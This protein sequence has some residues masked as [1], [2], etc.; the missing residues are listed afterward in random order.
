MIT[1]CVKLEWR[2]DPDAETILRDIA[3]VSFVVQRISLDQIDWAASA[4]N[5]AR[6]SD[7]LNKEKI[8]DY[9]SGF[10]RG[11]VFPRIVVEY[12]KNGLYTILGGNQRCAALKGID[13][14][15]EI[16][17]YVVDPLTSG[18]REL[19]I[20]SLNSRHGWG[21]T[22][23][24]RI[25][26]AAYLVRHH[27]MHVDTVAKAMVVAASTINLRI[28]AENERAS[29][30]KKGI[31]ASSVSRTALSSIAGIADEALK[32]R[33]AKLA[34]SKLAT[35]EKV[36]ELATAVSKAKSKSHAT[37][38]IAEFAKNLDAVAE[39]KNKGGA[40]VLKKPRREKFLCMLNDLSH[41]LEHGNDGGAFSTLDELSCTVVHDLDSVRVL[42]AKITSRLQCICDAGR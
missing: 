7:P 15:A 25:D 26:H 34:T 10:M 27:G 2:A 38:T 9:G 19:I 41:F 5:C 8:E 4:N 20:R 22:K 29:L 36:A 39:I 17:C 13:Q 12:G 21:A 28:R 16:E 37:A 1:Q 23:E 24:E 32:L 18:E 6:L 30:A 42:S 40:K 35:G 31:D 14:H 11:D 33:V 3:A